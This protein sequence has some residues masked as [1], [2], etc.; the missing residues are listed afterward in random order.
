[1]LR[2]DEALYGTG[3]INYNLALER[4]MKNVLLSDKL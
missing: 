3:K 2:H 4:K 1:M